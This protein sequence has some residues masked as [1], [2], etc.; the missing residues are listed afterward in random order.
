MQNYELGKMNGLAIQASAQ[1]MRE[2]REIIMRPELRQAIWTDPS[3]EREELLK[4]L[5]VYRAAWKAI[6]E[7]YS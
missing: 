2:A 6:T 1:A 3:E 5:Q 7:F 4:A